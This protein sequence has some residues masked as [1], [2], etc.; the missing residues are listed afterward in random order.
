MAWTT[1]KTWSNEP[2]VAGDMNEQLRDNLEALKS[3]PSDQVVL[4]ESSDFSTTSSVFVDIDAAVLSVTLETTGGAVL[5]TFAGNMRSTGTLHLN[6]DVD[7]SPVSPDDGI[8]GRVSS[9]ITP[10]ENMSFTCFIRGLSAGSHTIKLQWKTTGTAYLYAGAGTS[11]A[12]V[13]NRLEAVEIG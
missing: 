13:H 11:G 3:P 6:L 1:P 4:D 9:G 2:L 8:L 5:V 10:G 7:G 12:D